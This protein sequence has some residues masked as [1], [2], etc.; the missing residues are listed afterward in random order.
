MTWEYFCE[1]CRQLRVFPSFERPKTC[2]NCG[3]SSLDV[4]EPGCERLTRKRYGDKA[5]DGKVTAAIFK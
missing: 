5:P 4:D 3:G 1:A 2:G